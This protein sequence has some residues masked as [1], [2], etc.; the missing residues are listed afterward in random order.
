MPTE[1]PDIAPG[2][3]LFQLLPMFAIMFMIMYFMI[4]RPQRKKEKSRLEML[5]QIRKN[6]HILTT[7][8]IF[9]VVM[10]VKD[11]EL[12]LRIDDTNNVR[13]RISRSSVVGVID[14]KDKEEKSKD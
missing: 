9:G 14:P 7:G 10:N 2:G 5:S 1:Q 3:Q 11:D 13:V 8:G 12:L 4:I 6:D